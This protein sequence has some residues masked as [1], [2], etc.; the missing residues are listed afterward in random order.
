MEVMKLD[1][2]RQRSPI[3]QLYSTVAGDRRL[4]GSLLVYRK[5]LFTVKHFENSPGK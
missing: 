3:V 5:H 1:C 2:M 4:F